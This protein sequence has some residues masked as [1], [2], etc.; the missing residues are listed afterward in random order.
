M[1]GGH[2]VKV[3]DHLALGKQRG[4]TEDVSSVGVEN[5]GR[6]GRQRIWTTSLEE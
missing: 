4:V 1:T 6:G 3:K 5:R 2:L